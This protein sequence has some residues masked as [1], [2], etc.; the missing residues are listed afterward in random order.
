M[1]C[2]LGLPTTTLND[3]LSV[4]FAL[5]KVAARSGNDAVKPLVTRLIN[6]TGKS[7][8]F[9]KKKQKRVAKFSELQIILGPARPESVRVTPVRQAFHTQAA[10]P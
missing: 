10:F 1:V 5:T 8:F 4:H 2:G 7:Y 3:S 9:V 6:S